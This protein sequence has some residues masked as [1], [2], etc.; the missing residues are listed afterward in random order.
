MKTLSLKKYQKSEW[1]KIFSGYWSLLSCDYLGYEHT[2]I[3]KQ[4]LGCGPSR[5][6][7]VSHNGRCAC[8]YDKVDLKQFG[9][10]LVKLIK[11]DE[12]LIKKWCDTIKVNTDSL[13]SF[14][15]RQPNNLEKIKNNYPQ[16]LKMFHNYP[17]HYVAVKQT[18]N[19]LSP[20]L[21]KKFIPLCDD[22]RL[23]SENLYTETEEF[24]RK[25][26]ALIGKK[27]KY[28]ADEILSCTAE[29]FAKYLKSGKLPNKKVL[30]HRFKTNALIFEKGSRILVTGRIVQHLERILIG[31]LKA[32]EIHGTTAYPG[33]VQGKVRIVL[34]PL[35]I[36]QFDEGDVLITGMT[37][38]EFLPLMKKSSAVVTDAGGIL[39]H[40]AVVAREMKIPTII[41]TEKATKVFKDGDLVVVDANKGVVRMIK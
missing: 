1:V 10:S 38:P 27:T 22:S 3:I 16:F 31:S 17:A 37:R 18:P 34:N 13:I 7:I 14:I 33:H 24:M 41:G 15:K 28:T 20:E 40:A 4:E 35:K 12:T 32:K 9:K 36:K 39:C 8:H 11:K 30:A 21:F 19:F 5:A 6:I 25:F 23:Y 29:E 2:K 26:A